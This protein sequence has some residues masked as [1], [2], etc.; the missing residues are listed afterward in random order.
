[1]S[2]GE[3]RLSAIMF[4]DIVGYTALTQANESQAMRVLETHNQLIRPLIAKY[5]GIEVK[6]IGDSFLVEFGSALDAL[7]CAAEI[8]SALHAHNSSSAE[9]SKIR[10]RI[11]IHLGDVIHRE[12]DVFGDAVN[13]SSRIEQLAD[14]GAICISQQV[15]DQVRNKFE[16][17]MVP[18]GA[19]S[20]KNIDSPVEVYGVQMSWDGQREPAAT[21]ARRVAVLP[22]AN[23][24]PDPADEYFADGLTEELISTVSRIDGAEVISRTSVMQYK[25]SQKPVRQISSELE[26]GTV[27]EGSI[28]KA[29]NRLRVAVQMID[30]VR[31]RHIWAETYDR[32]LD[33]VFAIQSDI[34][35]KVADALKARMAKETPRSAGLTD[36][37]EAYTDY[38]R[39]KQVANEG[40]QT[41]TKEA[42]ALLES[43]IAKDPAFSRA[44]AELARVLRHMGSYEDYTATLKRAEEMGRRAIATGPEVAEAHAA[45]A[46]VHIALDRFEPAREE[47][48]KAVRLN[49]NLSDAHALLGEI[50][51]A[52]GEMDT[53]IAHYRKA[54]AL[55]PVSMHAGILMSEVLRASG[56]IEEG[57]QILYRAN[58][59]YPNHVHVFQGL[60]ACHIQLKDFD[61]ARRVLED[62]LRS[63]PN[64]GELRLTKG[65]LDAME[66]KR[67]SALEEMRALSAEGG[68]AGGNSKLFI[69]LALGNVDEAFAALDELARIHS[70]PFLIKSEPLLEGLR[71]DPR[72]A[73]F[74]RKVGIPP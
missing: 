50:T 38:L 59:L 10:V 20:L 55:D 25:K 56:R 23:L 26:A 21:D 69:N 32:D 52:F 57:L 35:G 37:V 71:K 22:F 54:Y 12:G 2:Q 42:I 41:K 62:G 67:E 60:A 65:V 68:T 6:T 43:A 4:T 13:I 66:G 45:M 49:P 61:S 33:D 40:G 63:N 7:R 11:G 27:L 24:S 17:P 53:S 19:K 18:L 47:L 73:D 31:D 39:A 34:A 3:R 14:P 74:C 28:R 48:E 15:Y 36:E 51:G 9:A 5:R 8:Q 64:D 44:Y 1:L 16:L 46:A 30:A 70:W 72:F 58:R 29:G